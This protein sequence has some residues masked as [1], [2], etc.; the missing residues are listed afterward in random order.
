MKK[1]ITLF[2]ILILALLLVGCA[3]KAA[4]KPT[5]MPG[6][7]T[8]GQTAIDKDVNDLDNVDKDVGGSSLDDTEK[9]LDLG[10]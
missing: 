7:G 10:F 2:L 1:T 9:D 6:K 5:T 8:E 4:E 3:K